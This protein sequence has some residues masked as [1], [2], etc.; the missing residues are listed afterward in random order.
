MQIVTDT[1][2]KIF[3]SAFRTAV[4]LYVQGNWTDCKDKLEECLQL[5]VSFTV[6]SD[7]AVRG[8]AIAVCSLP[9]LVKSLLLLLAVAAVVV[10]YDMHISFRRR[11]MGLVESSCR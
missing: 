2:Y 4:L 6:A 11:R 5:K 1:R 8:G 3:L 7:A 9:S 10:L